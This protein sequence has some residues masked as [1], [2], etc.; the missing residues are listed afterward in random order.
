LHP[1]GFQMRTGTSAGRPLRPRGPASHDRAAA[2]RI[3]AVGDKSA[4]ERR[5]DER[6]APAT[7]ESTTLEI[8]ARAL[9][10]ILSDV[11]SSGAKLF[12]AEEQYTAVRELLAEATS[13][14][15]PVRLRLHGGV[16][17]AAR[18]VW[19]GIALGGGFAVGVEFDPYRLS[20]LPRSGGPPAPLLLW[21]VRHRPEREAEL[22]NALGDMF[23]ALSSREFSLDSALALLCE[24]AH[25]LAGA[26]TVQFW[27]LEN[28]ALVLRAQVGALEMELGSQF[29]EQERFIP[30]FPLLKKILQRRQQLFA[31]RALESPFGENSGV[32]RFGL[33]SL[34]FI[35]VFGHQM[36]FGVLLFAHLKNPYAFG[37]RA[38]A[39]AEIFANQAAHFLE[40]AHSQ[41]VIRQQD[42][43][44]ILGE[45]AGV[46]AHEIKNALVPLRTLSDLLPER[47]D[48][49]DFREWYA[50]TVRQEVERMHELVAQLSRFQSGERRPAEL[51]EPAAILRNVVEML[52][53]E[54]ASREIT[55]E[56]QAEVGPP[57]SVVAN[58]LRQV[59]VNLVLNAIQAVDRGGVVRTGVR[60]GE[61]GRGTCCWVSDTGPGISS[62]KLERIFDPLFT[63]KENGSGLGLAVAR[64]L[65]KSNGGSIR[66]ESAPG[67]TT[68]T[69]LLP[70]AT[71]E[72]AKPRT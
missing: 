62:D 30:S 48:D 19:Y 63:T 37:S 23:R 2:F 60:R 56:F 68:F 8:G 52:R 13:S 15:T 22:A 1:L 67:A 49:A 41:R 7:E 6:S 40:V 27:A 70:E 46:V 33:Q 34:M 47:Y 3:A 17:S 53:P 12:F 51:V 58:E 55:L 10:G 38:Q 35:P 20:R 21:G 64:D 9:S 54:A 61:D 39:E 24:K 14:G 28:A 69:I 44:R 11:S 72:T 36:D 45:L 26:E 16:S 66:V 31:N 18:I 71:P 4:Q 29:P 43:F 25:A 5:A 42:R 65:V 50:R 59:L 57:V 32:L